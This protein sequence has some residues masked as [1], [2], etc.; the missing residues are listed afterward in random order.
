MFNSSLNQS[1]CVSQRKETDAMKLHG[2][3]RKTKDPVEA[4]GGGDNARN[5]ATN[6]GR[7]VRRQAASP[8]AAAKSPA[9]QSSSELKRRLPN[10]IAF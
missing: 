10:G 6:G 4:V 8:S 5:C 1:I 3:I 9:K 2:Y 7:S